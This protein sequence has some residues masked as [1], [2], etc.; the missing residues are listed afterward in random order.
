MEIIKCKKTNLIVLLI[1]VLFF[2]VSGCAFGQCNIDRT[3]RFKDSSI[4]TLT[5]NK[6]LKVYSY[7]NDTT[8]ISIL[9]DSVSSFVKFY[10]LY[11]YAGKQINISSMEL[12]IGFSNGKVKTFKPCVINIEF[13]YAEYNLTD[14]DVYIMLTNKNDMLKMDYDKGIEYCIGLNNASDY[15]SNF[16]KSTN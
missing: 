6:P 8:Y 5:P 2:L 14:D 10:K 3:F 7:K 15:F 9:M 16:I 13:N 1:A 12:S 11:I 4:V